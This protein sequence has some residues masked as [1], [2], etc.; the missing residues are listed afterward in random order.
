M[1]LFLGLRP[2]SSEES[3]R[4]VGPSSSLSIGIGSGRLCGMATVGKR[5]VVPA[6]AM[7]LARMPR[8]FWIAEDPITG[9]EAATCIVGSFGGDEGISGEDDRGMSWVG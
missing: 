9:E 4:Y 3:P 7:A 8:C 2:S 1:S 5:K 6:G